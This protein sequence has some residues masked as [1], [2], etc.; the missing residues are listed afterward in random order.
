MINDDETFLC[1][2]FFVFILFLCVYFS[3]LDIVVSQSFVRFHFQP[4]IKQQR[5]KE[6]F[7]MMKSNWKFI[8]I[9][10]VDHTRLLRVPLMKFNIIHPR[11]SRHR[12]LGVR[13]FTMFP[14]G[15]FFSCASARRQARMGIIKTAKNT[16]KKREREI[17][18]IIQIELKFELA[19]P[20]AWNKIWLKLRSALSSF[21]RF[22]WNCVYTTRDKWRRRVKL[23]G[24]EKFKCQTSFVCAWRLRVRWGK[25]NFVYEYHSRCEL[26][27]DLQFT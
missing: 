27:L 8:Q 12:R 23:W 3:L 22:H 7:N 20:Y 15:F 24:I 6:S 17:K 26:T 18:Q 9:F 13:C 4:T 2:C 14:N 21:F 19:D 11:E 25:I 5:K 16:L 10:T 1:E